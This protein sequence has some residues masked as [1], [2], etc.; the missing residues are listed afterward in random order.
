MALKGARGTVSIIDKATR[1][2]QSIAQAFSK[3]GQSSKKTNKD[4]TASQ[5]AINGLSRAQSRLG[6][7]QAGIERSTRSI[8]GQAVGVAAL[9][10]S[11]KKALDP[12][13]KFEQGMKNLEAVA[14]GTADSTVDVAGNMKLLSDQAKKLGA[15]TAFSATQAAEGQLFLAKA[16]FKTN[17][18]LASMRPL[19]DLAAASQTDLARASDITSDLLGAFGMKAKDTGKL[20]D[21]LAA[22]TSSANVDMETLFET[23]KVAAPIGISAGQSMEAIV[24]ATALLGNVGIKG[25]MAGTALKNALTNLASPAAAGAQ[26]LKELG[27]KTSDAAGN[28]LPLQK[29]MLNLGK[30]AKDLSQVKRIKAFD[31]VFGKIAMAGAINLEKAVTSGDFEKMLKNLQNSEGIASKMAKISMN[32]T[33]G[34]I[35]QL[36]SAVEGIAITFGSFLTPAIK[37]TANALTNLSEP[38]QNFLKNNESLIKVVGIF[39]A[40]L[41][42]AK[43]AVLAYTASL[44]LVSPAL[45]AVRAAIAAT[46]AVMVAFNFVASLNPFGAIITAVALLTAGL[47]LLYQ[48]WDKVTAAFRSFKDLIMNFSFD[49]VL[50]GLKAVGEMIGL[51]KIFGEQEIAVK[52]TITPAQ[53]VQQVQSNNVNNAQA[54]IIINNESGQTKSVETSGDFKTNIVTNDGMQQ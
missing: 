9:A 5:K 11:F 54:N 8:G 38:L 16:G 34:S 42:T 36:M 28:M 18:I 47:V 52:Q 21:V 15:T 12:A 37:N 23:L 50:N 20:A 14:F 32:S 43:I 30:K 45:T 4:L 25:S 13:I 46:K 48:N 7:T 40:V 3:M 24:S 33:Q 2:L 41:V 39:A 27:I 19:L 51:D 6:R 10:L 35:V 53:A 26:V 17:E 44:W 49:K 1:P 29:V 22:A 31:A